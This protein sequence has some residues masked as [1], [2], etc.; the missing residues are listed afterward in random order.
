MTTS[1]DGLQD[2]DRTWL[3]QGA[4]A[5]SPVAGSEVVSRSLSLVSSLPCE[6]VNTAPASAPYACLWRAH[7]PGGTPPTPFASLWLKAGPQGT[8]VFLPQRSHSGPLLGPFFSRPHIQIWTPRRLSDLE[9]ATGFLATVGLDLGVPVV[10]LRPKSPP[11]P[12]LLSM[13]CWGR[14]TPTQCPSGSLVGLPTPA[15]TALCVSRLPRSPL[16]KPW[17]FCRVG[18]GWRWA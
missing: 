14:L 4:T 5:H 15:Q 13:Q 12:C 8:L 9:G 1:L 10:S 18:S 2:P 3:C 17:Y 11:C 6:G 7:P 16:P